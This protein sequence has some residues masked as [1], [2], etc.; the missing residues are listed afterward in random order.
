MHRSR[1]AGSVVALTLL[2]AGASCAHRTAPIHGETMTLKV[3]HVV[4]RPSRG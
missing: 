4:I 2:L 3:A 1:L